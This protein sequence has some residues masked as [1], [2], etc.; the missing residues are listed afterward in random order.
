MLYTERYGICNPI[1]K[2]YEINLEQYYIILKCCEKYK[3][4]LIHIYSRKNYYDF[5]GEEYIEFD[6]EYF[7]TKLKI[8]IPELYRGKN[9][10]ITTPKEDEKYNQYAL[11]DYIEYI[12]KN[13]QDIEKKWN[14]EKYSVFCK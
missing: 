10:E 12:A 7:L 13:I 6:N 2:T 11:L 14:N 8:L 5:L 9:G 3:E 1:E 4:N